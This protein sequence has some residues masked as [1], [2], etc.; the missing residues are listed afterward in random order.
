[1]PPAQLSVVNLYRSHCSAHLKDRFS[2]NHSRLQKR[3][4]SLFKQQV[5]ER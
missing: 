3:L 2:I 1:M 4:F 5:V